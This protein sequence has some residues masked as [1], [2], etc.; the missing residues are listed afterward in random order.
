MRTIFWQGE[1]LV[2]VTSSLV[3]PGIGSRIITMD[4]YVCL[5]VYL[6]KSLDFGSIYYLFYTSIGVEDSPMGRFIL[7]N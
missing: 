4:S 1:P 2:V 7:Y 3:Q 5:S 6:A